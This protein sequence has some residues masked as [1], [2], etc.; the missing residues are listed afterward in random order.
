[1]RQATGRASS[2]VIIATPCSLAVRPGEARPCRGAPAV[3]AVAVGERAGGQAVGPVVAVGRVVEVAAGECPGAAARRGRAGRA[4]PARRWQVDDVDLARPGLGLVLPDHDGPV[5]RSSGP[6]RWC[7]RRRRRCLASPSRADLDAAAA[8]GAE[9]PRH[10]GPLDVAGAG[11]DA[12]VLPVQQGGRR[13]DDR[14]ASIVPPVGAARLVGGC[15][16]RRLRVAVGGLVARAAA[17]QCDQQRQRDRRTDPHVRRRG[18]AGSGRGWRGRT[19]RRCATA[20]A[21]WPARWGRS[22]TG[23]TA[24][25]SRSCGCRPGPGRSRGRP[26]SG[27]LASSSR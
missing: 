26:G 7:G 5:A 9:R 6:R 2:K 14:G 8:V 10:S 17:G 3:L 15:A 21:R 13:L 27:P 22:A 11:L 4:R 23:P 20:R 25:S 24:R 1:M 19:C 18:C 12:G 16:G